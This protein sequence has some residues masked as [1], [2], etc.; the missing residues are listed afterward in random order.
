MCGRYTLAIEAIDL[1]DEFGLEEMPVE[2]RP[3]YNVAPSQPAAVI[4][5]KAPDT[6]EWMR[7]G[8]V[9]SWA[10]DPAIGSRLI[11][12]RSETIDEKPSFRNAFHRRRCLIL[13][14]GFF[15]WQHLDK[16]TV[17]PHYFFLKDKKPFAFAGLWEIWQNAQGD[18]LLS[19]AIITCAANTLL[20]PI[21]ERMPVILNREQ[22]RAWLSDVPP[23]EL[24]ALMTPFPAE[25]MDAYPVS[26]LVNDPRQDSPQVL[27]KVEI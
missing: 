22:R 10:K 24:K 14:N 15:E 5:A 16:G 18:E 17:I 11:N 12:A 6:L 3:R 26:R 25:K 21:H 13:A 8:L 19:C 23:G 2:W 4:T 9:P 1:M 7:W 27:Q 20:A